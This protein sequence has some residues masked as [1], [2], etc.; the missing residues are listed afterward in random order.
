MKLNTICYVLLLWLNVFNP[1]DNSVCSMIA[2]GFTG[3]YH[4]LSYI[5][6]KIGDKQ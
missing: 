5:N 1:S 2:I 3:L 6:G 4:W